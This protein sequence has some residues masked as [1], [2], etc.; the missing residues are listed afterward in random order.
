MSTK[1]KITFKMIPHSEERTLRYQISKDIL[2]YILIF[3]LIVLLTVANGAL[4]YKYKYDASLNKVKKLVAIK[5]KVPKLKERNKYLKQKLA[6]LKTK[7]KSIKR[8]FK[9]VKELNQD[10]GSMVGVSLDDTIDN[11]SVVAAYTSN[12]KLVDKGLAEELTTK[13]QRLDKSLSQRKENL[14][15][16]KEDTLTYLDYLES[17]PQGWPIQGGRGRITSEF[18]IRYH[19]I[20]ERRAMHEG[21]DIAIWYGTRLIAT[22][23][24]VVEHAGWYGGYGNAVIIDHGYGYKT[25]YT[26]AKRLLVSEGERVE[27]GEAVAL[28]GSTGRSTGPHTHYEIIYNGKSVDPF[29]YMPDYMQRR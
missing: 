17:K 18:G 6:K 24:G 20:L 9:Q 16:L 8:E 25:L 19:P 28:S 2:E 26:H 5:Q 1:E 29:D 23:E 3:T 27:R 11:K 15:E 13:L 21:I 14:S 22:G 10:V 7:Q 12:Q 4:Y